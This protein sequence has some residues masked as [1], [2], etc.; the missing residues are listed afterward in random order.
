M[1]KRKDRLEGLGYRHDKSNKVVINDTMDLLNLLT[2][3]YNEAPECDKYVYLWQHLTN[4]V[5]QSKIKLTTH[6]VENIIINDR[7]VTKET[8][9]VSRI[10]NFVG[11][12]IDKVCNYTPETE[13]VS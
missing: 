3:F 4:E 7:R 5:K 1:I 6:F 12:M 10:G 8:T 9:K 2:D 11:H 13:V